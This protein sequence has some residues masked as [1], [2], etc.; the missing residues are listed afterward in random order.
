MIKE[1]LGSPQMAQM[2]KIHL[3]CRRPRFS[4]RVKKIPWKNTAPLHGKEKRDPGRGKGIEKL[5][6]CDL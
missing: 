3:Q 6:V 2:I 4:L 5:S 1:K